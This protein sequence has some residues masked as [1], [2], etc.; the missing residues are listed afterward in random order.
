MHGNWRDLRAHLVQTMNRHRF[1]SHFNRLQ[2]GYPDLAVFADPVSLLDRLHAV[3]ASPDEK[4]N[5]LRAIVAAAQEGGETA[6]AALVL[7]HLALWPGLDAVQRRLIVHYRSE[8]EL[9]TSEIA[10]RFTDGVRGMNLDRV[11]R[12]AATLVRNVERDIRRSLAADWDRASHHSDLDE[13]TALAASGPL[14]F[15]HIAD[16]GDDA[17]LC[18]LE[19]HL[20]RLIGRDAGLV[21]DVAVG[22]ASQREAAETR[23]LTPEAGRKRYRRALKRLRVD[24]AA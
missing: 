20:S 23:G 13:V 4:N 8:P 15:T 14:V 11:N 22:G 7:I 9:L 18:R 3:G 5:L 10:A 17:A 19:D 6:D 21:I 16:I 2:A 12:I 1:R 24:L